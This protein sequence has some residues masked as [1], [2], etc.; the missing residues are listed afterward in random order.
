MLILLLLVLH[1]R[2]ITSILGI[3]INKKSI[4]LLSSSMS[5]GMA[6]PYLVVGRPF[7]LTHA[8]RLL[9]EQSQV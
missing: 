9:P 7:L 4:V 1:K 8:L 2:N 3:P 6:F 5:I